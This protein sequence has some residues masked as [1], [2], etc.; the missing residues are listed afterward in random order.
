MENI[1]NALPFGLFGQRQLAGEVAHLL[2][3]LLALGDVDERRQRTALLLQANGR[4]GDEYYALLAIQQPDD[5]LLIAQPPLAAVESRHRVAVALGRCS[6]QVEH[7]AADD[8]LAG[9]V[10]EGQERLVGVDGHQVIN[11]Q[12]DLS[13]IHI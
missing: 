7:G 4:V 9:Q 13:L 6:H 8:L 1:G 2:L 11:A 3:G 12:D 10:V 5:H